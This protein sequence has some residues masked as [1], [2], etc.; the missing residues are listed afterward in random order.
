MVLESDFPP[1]I[2]VENEIEA[3]T[4][5]GYR[6]TLL[7][8][9]RLGNRSRKEVYSDHLTVYREKMSTFLYKSKVGQL[10]FPFYD[11]FWK[12]FIKKHLRLNTDKDYDIIHVHDLSLAKVGIWLKKLLKIPVILDLHENYPYLIK[13]AK[14]TQK[15]LGKL[16]SDYKQWLEFEKEIVPQADYVIC[17]VKEMQERLMEFDHRP[18]NYHIYQNVVNL[19]SI[20]PYLRPNS[21]DTFKLIYIGGITPARGIQTVIEAIDL[22]LNKKYNIIFEI[23][24]DGS[25]LV[26]LKNK[27]QSSKL[28]N[29]IH[30]KGKI[31]Q[32][33]IFD[34][35]QDADAS[36][37]P[38]YKSVQNNCSSPN[39][40]YQYLS[41]GRVVV[42][43]DCNSVMRVIKENNIGKT[44][45]D[46]SPQDL[47]DVLE[48]LILNPNERIELGKSGYELVNNKFNTVTEGQKLITFYKRITN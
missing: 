33:D 46:K 24:G 44:Y 7:C 3:L 29:Q 14:H 10:K 38:H 32:N 21:N 34:K 17:V 5:A 30:F 25:Y 37:I 4:N 48:N 16:L 15:G 42:A 45:K 22:L 18:E 36:I 35:I 6:I 39:K 28:K 8:A 41:S 27:T 1:D 11:L 47:A 20:K 13:D 2:R 40:L 31:P 26:D 23:Y 9:T 43:S 19:K 12:S